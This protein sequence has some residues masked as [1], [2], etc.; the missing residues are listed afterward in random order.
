MNAIVSLLIQ[1][2]TAR[3]DGMGITVHVGEDVKQYLVEKYVNLQYGARPLKRAVQS[4][5]EDVVAER[6]L[7]GDI[8]PGDDVYICME[9]GKVNLNVNP[10]IESEKAGKTV[11]NQK[12]EEIPAVLAADSSEK[13][14]MAEEK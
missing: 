1:D 11:R 8:L 5:V 10:N 4:E 12:A 2:L 3:C 6:M 7:S 13:A 9:E 14:E